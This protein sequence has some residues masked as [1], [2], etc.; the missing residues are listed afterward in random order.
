M[1]S[2]LASAAPL[3]P[4]SL[5]DNEK[6]PLTLF[7]SLSFSMYSYQKKKKTLKVTLKKLIS[8]ILGAMVRD[9]I[10]QNQLNIN[11]TK[12]LS[13][14]HHVL[15]LKDIDSYITYGLSNYT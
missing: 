15:N 8:S 2:Y 3:H 1:H 14:I 6:D 10:I 4:E 5:I 9:M 13:M 12:T 11:N 7:Y